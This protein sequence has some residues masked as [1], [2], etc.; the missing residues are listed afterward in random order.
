MIK[1]TLLKNG[2]SNWRIKEKAEVLLNHY[3][4]NWFIIAI[5]RIG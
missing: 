2:I 4:W 3:C 5:F 1:L